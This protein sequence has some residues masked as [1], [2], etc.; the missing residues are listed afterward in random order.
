MFS[1]R[2]FLIEAIVQ[3]QDLGRLFCFMASTEL[4]KEFQQVL[5]KEIGLEL[6]D[7]EASK[8]LSNLVSYFDL[9][10][11]LHHRDQVNVSENSYSRGN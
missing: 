1:F 10:A 3:V 11:L 9:L 6:D 2:D 4:T 8:I 7:K 5:Y